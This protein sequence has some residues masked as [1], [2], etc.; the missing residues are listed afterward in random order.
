M[1]LFPP[2]DEYMWKMLSSINR[3]RG[4]SEVHI[5]NKIGD[6][7]RFIVDPFSYWVFTTSPE[8]KS[9]LARAKDRGLNTIDAI[10]Y[11]ADMMQQGKKP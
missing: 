7:F 6:I 8:D 2:D 1:G 5:H 4:Y 11:C 10:K 9:A 3:G